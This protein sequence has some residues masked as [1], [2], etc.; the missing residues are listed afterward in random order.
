M[1]IKTRKKKIFQKKMEEID[2]RE[3]VQTSRDMPVAIKN[4]K[5][6]NSIY[7]NL[8]LYEKKI[9]RYVLSLI[10]KGDD[11]DTTFIIVHKKIK[12]LFNHNFTSKEIHDMLH[13]VSSSLTLIGTNK[14]GKK[15]Y[16]SIPIFKIIDTSEDNETTNV[17]FNE[18]YNEFVFF[19]SENGHF[20][21]YE[22]GNII[23]YKYLHS[24]ELFE[25]LLAKVRENK[26]D[27]IV[28]ISYNIEELKELLDCKDMRTNNFI[29]QVI[30]K[31]VE[32]L[33]KYNISLLGGTIDYKYNK[34]KKIISF[35]V[36][37]IIYMI[38]NTK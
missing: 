3:R 31:S 15:R 34:T 21:K 32:E 35:Y 26:K 14:N 28:S 12:E 36:E 16:L 20:L 24:P 22:L 33:N 11:I 23:D 30:K 2:K 38:K 18:K 1:D 5:I 27:E 9:Y 29:N 13:K 4:E 25:M 10:K 37:N 7:Q 6:F 17:V 8:N 19:L